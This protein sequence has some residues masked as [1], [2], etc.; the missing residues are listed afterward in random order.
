MSIQASFLR[1]DAADAYT[2]S[3]LTIELGSQFR[4]RNAGFGLRLSDGG[5]IGSQFIY[6]FDGTSETGQSLSWDDTADRFQFSNDLHVNG[7]LFFGSDG[8]SWVDGGLP[9]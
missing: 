8:Q 4:Y 2:G 9:Q 6:F 7:N 3:A 1:S 5:S